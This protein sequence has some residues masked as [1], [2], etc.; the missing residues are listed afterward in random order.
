[1]QEEPINPG[2]SNQIFIVGSPITTVNNTEIIGGNKM[3]FMQFEFEPKVNDDYITVRLISLF[4]EKSDNGTIEIPVI[5]D[6]CSYRLIKDHNFTAEELYPIVE[7]GTKRL[8]QYYEA[9][10][11]IQLDYRQSPYCPQFDD[12]QIQLEIL[13]QDLNYTLLA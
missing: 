6:R 9:D 1:M 5:T 12:I 10:N 8:I 13:V 7:N 4:I 11:K 2:Y 3:Q